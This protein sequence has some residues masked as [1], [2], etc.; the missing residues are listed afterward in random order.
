MDLIRQARARLAA[1][2]V[3]VTGASSGIGRAFVEAM[4]PS[5]ARFVLVARRRELLEQLADHVRDSGS[6]AMVQALDLRDVEAGRAAAEEVL[7]HHGIP[8]VLFSNAGH[9]IARGLRGLV[10]R[11]DS[12][13]RSVAAN[14]TG[15]VCHALPLLGAMCTRGG[16]HFIATTTVDARTSVPGWSPNVASKA[17]WDAWARSVAPELRS[18]GVATSLLAFPLVATPMLPPARRARARCAM[19]PEAAAEWVAR[20]VV[21]RQARVAPW[22]LRPH[23]LL[24]AAAPV[25]TARVTA[26]FSM[27]L[28]DRG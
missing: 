10:A 16:G 1:R 5:G 12:V 23:E 25:L 24:H 2:L 26:P 21:T 20:A 8:E 19:S 18:D 17:G 11:P 27:R 4:A 14:F 6:H 13:T 7:A 28:V 22:W 3:V 15:P 9:S